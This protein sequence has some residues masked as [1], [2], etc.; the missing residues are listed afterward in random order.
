MFEPDN[1]KARERGLYTPGQLAELLRKAEGGGFSASDLAASELLAILADA[2]PARREA[3]LQAF[4]AE[5]GSAVQR[6]LLVKLVGEDALGLARPE[7]PPEPPPRADPEPPTIVAVA[8]EPPEPPP[9]GKPRIPKGGPKP[10]T[11][12]A[13]EP[14]EELAQAA[15][16]RARSDELVKEGEAARRRGDL[17]AAERLFNQALAAFSR[18]GAALMGLS[19]VEFDRGHFEQAVVFAERAVKA[20]PKKSDFRIRLGDAYFK[21]LRY[22][23]ARSQYEKAAEMGHPRAAARID[24]VKEKLGG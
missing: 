23:D 14:E 21:V 6:D 9:T 18:N 2:D 7:P 16:D 15:Q 1:A 8:P 10:D 17:D 22:P 3:R 11:K 20:E 5:R 4:V 19:D 12:A 24:K 13:P